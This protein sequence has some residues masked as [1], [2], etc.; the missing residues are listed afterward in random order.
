MN[1][2]ALRKRL[3]VA[4][5]EIN[6]VQLGRDTSDLCEAVRGLVGTTT[7]FGGIVSTGLSLVSSLTDDKRGSPA[8]GAGLASWLGHLLSGAKIVS[9]IWRMVGGRGDRKHPGH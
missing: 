3:L 5:S 4:E 9:T 1:Q 8:S 6:R 2:L 7:T